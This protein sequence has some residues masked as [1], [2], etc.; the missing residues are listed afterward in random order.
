[1]KLITDLYFQSFPIKNKTI[2]YKSIILVQKYNQTMDNDKHQKQ[3]ESILLL[4]F[5]VSQVNCY[6]Q[7]T[8]IYSSTYIINL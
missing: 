1:M 5:Q 8:Y 2:L 4:T 6:V 3:N 7:H